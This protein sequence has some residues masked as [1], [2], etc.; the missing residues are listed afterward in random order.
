RS[1]K[2]LETLEANKPAPL[3][4]TTPKLIALRK[5][6]GAVEALLAYMPFIEEE[7]MAEEMQAALNA[8]AFV[9]GE[10][11]PTVLKG[12]ADKNAIRRG[13]AGA[14]LANGPLAKYMPVLRRLLKDK[15]NDVRL[16]VALALAGAREAESVPALIALVGEHNPEGSLHAEEYLVKLAGN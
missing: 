13:A 11:H 7:G 16:K 6:K 15:D 8:V 2:I 3:S 9:K 4:A 5:P 1:G 14:A 10:P 12:V